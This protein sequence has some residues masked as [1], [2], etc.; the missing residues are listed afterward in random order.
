VHSSSEGESEAAA[1]RPYLMLLSANDGHSLAENAQS[2]QRHVQEAAQISRLDLSYTLGVRRSKLFHRGFSIL[3]AGAPL[4]S[5]FSQEAMSSAKREYMEPPRLGF[6]FTGQGAQRP[7]MGATLLRDF[8]S[9]RAT[10]GRLDTYLAALPPQNRPDWT[11]AS[12]LMKSE[13]ETRI[14]D[15]RFAQP[16]TCAV[17]IAVANLLSEWGVK[18]DAGVVGHS[19]GEIPAAYA[20]GMLTERQAI[21]VAYFRGFSITSRLEKNDTLWADAGMLAVGLGSQEALSKV[22]ELQSDWQSSFPLDLVVAC[23][24]S[25]FA[26]PKQPEMSLTLPKH[27]GLTIDPS[28]GPDSVTISGATSGLD[29]LATK[30]VAEGTFARK[31]KVPKAYH[32]PHYMGRYSYIFKDALEASGTFSPKGHTPE[33]T[34]PMYSSTITGVRVQSVDVQDPEYWR[35]NMEGTVLFN[36]ALNAMLS[37]PQYSSTRPQVL[38]EIGPSSTLKGPIRQILTTATNSGTLKPEEMPRYI[39]TLI[40]GSNASEDVLRTAGNLFTLGYPVD[41]AKVNALE[42]VSPIGSVSHT[43]GRTIVDLPNYAWN[44][45]R[46]LWHEPRASRN[47]RFK[48]FRRHEILGSRVPDDNPLVPTWRNFLSLSN[49]KWLADHKINDDVVFPAAGY[50]TMAIEAV[51]QISSGTSPQAYG[52]DEATAFELRN[53]QIKSALVLNA[54]P[55]TEGGVYTFLTLTRASSESKW[56]SFSVCS[57][58]PAPSDRRPGPL[59]RDESKADIHCYGEIAGVPRRGIE[60]SPDPDIARIRRECKGWTGRQAS[61]HVWYQNF[62]RIGYNYTNT[63]Q[64]LSSLRAP[65]VESQAGDARP[66]AEAVIALPA[67]A[68][69][70]SHYAVAPAVIDG[71][72]Q[73][74]LTTSVW[75]KPGALQNLAVPTKI[76][77]LYVAAPETGSTSLRCSSYIIPEVQDSEASKDGILGSAE[78]VDERTGQLVIA[79]DKLACTNINQTQDGS[80][81]LTEVHKVVW[82]PDVSSLGRFEIGPEDGPLRNVVLDLLAHQNPSAKWL[83]VADAGGL[84]TSEALKVLAPKH[85][86]PRLASYTLSGLHNEDLGPEL[87]ENLQREFPAANFS[88]KTLNLGG[89]HSAEPEYDMVVVQIASVGEANEGWVQGARYLLKPKGRFVLLLQKPGETEPSSLPFVLE[90]AGSGLVLEADITTKTIPDGETQPE[91]SRA[92]VLKLVEQS[93]NKPRELE[94]EAALLGQRDRI[95]SILSPS[96]ETDGGH[97]SIPLTIQ[98]ADAIIFLGGLSNAEILASVSEDTWAVVKSLISESTGKSKPVIWLTRGSQLD[99]KGDSR[100][101]NRVGGAMAVGLSRSLA[102]EEPDLALLTV[103][104]DDS[105]PAADLPLLLDRLLRNVSVNGSDEREFSIRDGVIYV[106]RI[107]PDIGTFEELHPAPGQATESQDEGQDQLQRGESGSQGEWK[108]QIRQIGLLQ[109]LSFAQVPPAELSQPLGAGEVEV[110]MRAVGV[111]FKDVAICMGILPHKNFGLEF[112]GVVTRVGAGVSHLRP[113]QRVGGLPSLHH[114]AYRSLIRAPDWLCFEIPDTMSFEEAATMPCV[115][116]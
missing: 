14:H 27:A 84:G 37:K 86:F 22:K 10:L 1:S 71:V 105:T 112:A 31:L 17:Q 116:L 45:S 95:T 6:I 102:K 3:C 46:A 92:L 110:S 36:D 39:P 26:Y 114:G 32:N 52:A 47:H 64:V 19:S 81:G 57:Q 23:D 82:K 70:R 44:K 54:A 59:S 12:E 74:L 13:R 104:I 101:E 51:R 38:I 8:P 108:L 20:A 61:P 5:A 66:S 28:T 55:N 113:G 77:G 106:N 50:I 115:Y 90:Q 111:N 53:I 18:P 49:T 60:L 48:Q 33:V 42:T 109:T 62:S 72:L 88:Y 93:P 63:F 40:G 4:E 79:L 58:Q 56:Y 16:L 85:G 97:F 11:F 83:E 94:G 35:R 15:P 43:H 99:A 100:A 76:D 7:G 73:T 89:M 41:M 103:D 34:A 69:L 80:G 21:T 2:L 68:S 67:A 107:V 87:E 65:A 24:N 25:K 75:G 98:C 30:L 91:I 29:A 9:V 78:A 96:M